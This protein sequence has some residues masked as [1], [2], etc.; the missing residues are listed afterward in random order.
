VGERIVYLTNSL[1]N[2]GRKVGGLNGRLYI[3]SVCTRVITQCPFCIDDESKIFRERTKPLR[4]VNKFWDHVENIHHLELAAFATG[5]KP[6][7]ICQAKG[8]MFTL[9]KH[10]SFQES[11]S[12]A[13]QDQTPSIEFHGTVSRF[14]SC[15]SCK[16]PAIIKLNQDYAISCKGQHQAVDVTDPNPLHLL[17]RGPVE[18]GADLRV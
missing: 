13:A 18:R 3:H 1:A 12:E 11:Y 15:M 10:F 8:I 17:S 4:R 16:R 9:S 5:H 2:E 7:L 14:S 6:C